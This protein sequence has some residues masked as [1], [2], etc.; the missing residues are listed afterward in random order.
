MISTFNICGSGQLISVVFD[1]EYLGTGSFQANLYMNSKTVV[2]CIASLYS[3]LSINVE[4]N[5]KPC[6]TCQ[7]ANISTLLQM[8]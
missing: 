7:T 8:S 2:D 4:L 1:K 6:L 5:M 3:I